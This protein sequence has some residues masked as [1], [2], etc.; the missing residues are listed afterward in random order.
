VED[1]RSFAGLGGDGLFGSTAVAVHDGR[2]R[3]LV[4]ASEQ[5]FAS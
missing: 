4:P 1:S 2:F 5:V 3:A